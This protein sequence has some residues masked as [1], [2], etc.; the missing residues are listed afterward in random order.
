MDSKILVTGATGFLGKRLVTKLRAM[1][2]NVVAADLLT[3]DEVVSLDVRDKENVTAAFESSKPEIVVHLAA[4]N[5]NNPNFDR[6]YDLYFN[7]IQGT[8]NICEAATRF[9]VR[10]IVFP[11]STSIYGNVRDDDLPISEITRTQ[12][13]TPYATSK[14]CEEMLVRDYA[15]RANTK[16]VVF[17][18]SIIYG[19][20]QKHANVVE[21]FMRKAISGDPIE[22]L[23]DGSHTRE[24][25]YVDDAIDALVAGTNSPS[26]P[27]DT[28][29]ISTGKPIKLRQLAEKIS[30]II[31]HDVLIQNT[32]SG[33]VFSQHY[34]V[35]RAMNN[36]N[37]KP[38][39]PLDD[40]L[41]LMLEWVRG[42]N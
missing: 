1:N 24:F 41:S 29:L 23:G 21:Q 28:F 7:N 4:I 36:L 6:P 30:M 13:L 40:G 19:P 38:R 31:D 2:L 12:P 3:T 35:S 20:E 14:V 18:F 8:L 17:R 33:Q 15:R 9:G 26:L 39:V 42:P 34:D 27:Y 11:S 37:W 5:D 10:K 32:R 16:L 22:L 25:L